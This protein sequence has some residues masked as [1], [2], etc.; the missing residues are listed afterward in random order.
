LAAT[1]RSSGQEASR[2][3]SYPTVKLEAYELGERA[4]SGEAGNKCVLLAEDEDIPDPIGQPEETYNSCA[5]MIEE[6]VKKRV[7]ELVI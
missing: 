3:A 6:A 5:E 2:H 7:D 4:H 1:R